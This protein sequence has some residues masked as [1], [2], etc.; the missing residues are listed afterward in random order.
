[1]LY[2]WYKEINSKGRAKTAMAMEDLGFF[3][4]GARFLCVSVSKKGGIKGVEKW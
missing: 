2:G 4:N 3:G 1:M